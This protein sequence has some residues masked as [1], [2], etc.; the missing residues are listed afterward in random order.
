MGAWA[1][2][3]TCGL[4]PS[5]KAKFGGIDTHP[6]AQAR[7]PAWRV[8][9]GTSRSREAARGCVAVASRARTALHAWVRHVAERGCAA[10]WD[11]VR[12]LLA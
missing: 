5:H 12:A 9:R 2:A 11:C 7:R 1:A 8:A 3:K 4:A 10:A 6:E